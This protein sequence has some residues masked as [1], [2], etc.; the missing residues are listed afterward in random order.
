[1]NFDRNTIMGFAILAILFFGFFYYTNKQQAAANK[2]KFRTDSIARAKDSIDR[3]KLARQT[4]LKAGDTSRTDSSKLP[5]DTG[6]L[7]QVP[8]Q[9]Y[10]VGNEVMTVYFSNK[11][12]QPKYVELKKFKGPDSNLVKLAGTP[13]DKISYT[14]K[15]GNNNL[16]AS[17]LF[18]TAS[19]STK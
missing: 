4:P 1:M 13:F 3:S 9:L 16:E 6:L 15:A 11:G 10:P 2:E 18:F 14:I 5:A 17:D 7:K 12:G 19:D 8:E